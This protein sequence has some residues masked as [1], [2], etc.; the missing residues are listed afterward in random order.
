MFFTAISSALFFALLVASVAV[1][2]TDSDIAARS[3]QAGA[4]LRAQYECE[5]QGASHYLLCLNLW[6]KSSAAS[7][8]WQTAQRQTSG[9]HDIAWTTSYD[10]S[11]GSNEIKSY[12]NVALIQNLPI[13]LSNITNCR[14]NWHWTYTAQNNVVADV[15]YDI[16]F[17]ASPVSPPWSAQA[18]SGVS[19]YEI[20]IWLSKV[21]GMGPIGSPIATTNIAGHTWKLWK[22]TN[23]GWT[24]FSFLCQ[25]SDIKKFSADLNGFFR[26]LID[27]QGVESS[28]YLVGLESGTEP[29]KGSAT[30]ATSLYNVA[31]NPL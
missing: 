20:M 7:R 13:Q 24:V 27:H 8:S 9:R 22:G 4:V 6:G 31:V 18:V 30:L 2:S 12:S 29:V 16:W 15:S 11:G 17:A 10:W 26:Y 25:G 23:Q 14:S 5:A 19:T 21:G 1:P 28:Q 3:T